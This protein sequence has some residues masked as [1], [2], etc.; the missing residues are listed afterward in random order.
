MISLT[1]LLV[2]LS[3][4]NSSATEPFPVPITI[5]A[6]VP[7]P[8]SGELF[9]DAEARKLFLLL[10][11][12]RLRAEIAEAEVLAL[13]EAVKVAE[14][15][16]R[17]LDATIAEGVADLEIQKAKCPT[18]SE[19]HF[20]FCGGPYMGYNFTDQEVDAGVGITW[21]YRF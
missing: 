18:W 19:I 3:G 7:A 12:R 1:M 14:G 15:R 16:I 21:G 2:A 5:K 10:T 8:M 4:T 6:G 20:G 17:V 13:R 11:E 9:P